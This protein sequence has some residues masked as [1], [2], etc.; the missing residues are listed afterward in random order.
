MSRSQIVALVIGIVAAVGVA[1]LF[2]G[3]VFFGFMPNRAGSNPSKEVL[4]PLKFELL[5]RVQIPNHPSLQ[6]GNG[7]F[8]ISF[9]FRTGTDRRYIAF[10]AKRTSAMGDGWVVGADDKDRFSFYTAG[11]ASPASS[12]QIF[13]Y[14]KW[15]H[16]GVVRERQTMT[17]YFD[18]QNVGSGPDTCNHNDKNPIK[19]GMDADQGWHFDG[20][21]AEVHFYNRALSLT[22][23]TE[24]WNNGKGRNSAVAAGGLIAGYHFNEKTGS[25]AIDF[26]GNGHNGTL[27]RAPESATTRSN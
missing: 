24:E 1:L 3:L 8:T 14:R 13:K 25:T 22:E 23:V 2:L 11:C 15:H 20:E 5:N 10:L 17:F 27:I 6:F 19:I 26:S 12:P 18:N 21:I 9:W 4:T 16:L 7:P